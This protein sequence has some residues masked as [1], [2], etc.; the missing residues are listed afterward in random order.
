MNQHV[1]RRE[2]CQPCGACCGRLEALAQVRRECSAGGP[3]ATE[4]CR[5]RR[6]I[7]KIVLP[8]PARNEVSDNCTAL[9]VTVVAKFPVPWA[10]AETAKPV[11]FCVHWKRRLLGPAEKAEPVKEGARGTLVKLEASEAGAITGPTEACP[12]GVPPFGC[13]N[14]VRKIGM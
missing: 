9:R 3:R 7:P 2:T 8:D 5:I 1:I 6:V 11:L 12:Q 14:Q 13:P 4:P 10:P